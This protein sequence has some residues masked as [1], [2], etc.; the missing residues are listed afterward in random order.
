MFDVCL[1]KVTCNVV[2]FGKDKQ[3]NVLQD[4]N[5]RNVTDNPRARPRSSQAR[6]FWHPSLLHHHHHHVNNS[7]FMSIQSSITSYGNCSILQ[8]EKYGNIINFIFQV[9][10]PRSEN[11]GHSH[12]LTTMVRV[13]KRV[14]KVIIIIEDV[15]VKE[16]SFLFM[17]VFR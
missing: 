3:L 6:R 13:S 12:S 2:H 10:W 9:G 14:V 4:P 17:L 1:T 16:D 5:G 15:I 8:H 7:A 11:N